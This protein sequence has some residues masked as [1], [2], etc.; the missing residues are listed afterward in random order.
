MMRVTDII[1]YCNTASSE[2]EKAV[3]H[4]PFDHECSHRPIITH[5]IIEKAQYKYVFRC[6]HHSNGFVCIE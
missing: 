4:N 2:L 1:K 3:I 6:V 5:T